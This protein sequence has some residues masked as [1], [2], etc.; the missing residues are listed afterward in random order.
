MALMDQVLRWGP[1]VLALASMATP[2]ASQTWPVT[3][4][5]KLVPGDGAAGDEFGFSVARWGNRIL[6][7]AP[8]KDLVGADSGAAY[9]YRRDGDGWTLE[10]Q[11]TPNDHAT[12]MRFGCSVSLV[13]DHALVGARGDS[14]AGADS[15]SAYV[16]FREGSA[17]IQQ[18]K[19]VAGVPKAGDAFGVCVALDTLVAERALIGARAREVSGHPEAGAAYVFL[20]SGT[21]WTKEEKL[22][23][24]FPSDWEQF[25]ASVAI[26]GTTLAVGARFD[27]VGGLADAGRVHVFEHESGSWTRKHRIHATDYAQG[28]AFG[29]GVVL[30]GNTMVVQS[31]HDE[32]DAGSAYVFEYD[33][34]QSQ[35]IEDQK[36]VGSDTT[37]GDR[38]GSG[39]A[40]SGDRLV[41]GAMREDQ[42][43]ADA[44]AAYLFDRSPG[45][46]TEM[47]KF[48]GEDT[49]AGD[50][51][52][53]WVALQGTEIVVGAHLHDAGATDVGAAHVFQVGPGI[54][55]C[56]AMAGARPVPAATRAPSATA[57][58]TRT[59]RRA[60]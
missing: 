48:F 9:V 3:E 17:W 29:N 34:V 14:H 43:G 6:V 54:S 37:A 52:G 38:F 53:R 8:E 2:A 30:E 42:A 22:L 4:H 18:A 44:G 10:Q 36:L 25:G 13:G 23:S 58:G 5:L 59:P 28:D 47:G 49:A 1:Q 40:L 24:D 60:R 19:L 15:G 41:V 46:W 51:L 57:A 32:S 39:L 27:H 35:W 20:R 26:E 45:S 50:E 55:F 12:G 56:S 31:L 16:F 33:A 11:L 7:G 21:I